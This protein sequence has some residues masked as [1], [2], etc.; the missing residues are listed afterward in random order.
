MK[1]FFNRIGEGRPL[2]ILHGLF[3]LGDNWATLARRLAEE[4]FA[5]YLVDQRNHGRSP[6]SPDFSYELMADDLHGFLAD[7]G[8]S[9]PV[10]LGHSMG[11]KTVIRFVQEHPGTAQKL[12]VVD[13]A[14]RYYPPHHQAVLAA[15]Q[16]VDFEQ[17]RSRRQAEEILRNAL[18]EE[19]TVQFL[20]KNL[21]WKSD[22][23]LDWRFNLEV[24]SRSIE[25]VGAAMPEGAAISAP[26]LFVRGERSGYISAADEA[27]IRRRFSRVEVV[28]VP[29]AGHWVHAENPT[30]F[31]EAVLPFLRS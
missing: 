14:P 2:V 5:C 23:R 8:L 1:L 6:H 27:E 26:T 19:A 20:L 7:N 15:L 9:D 10:L 13:I 24:L 12:I 21:Y 11:G 25:R 29:Q 31:L 3:G 18:H 17:V 28:T 30:G 22:D 4:G 16:A